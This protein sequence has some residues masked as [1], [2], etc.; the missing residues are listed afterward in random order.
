MAKVAAVAPLD[1]LPGIKAAVTRQTLDGKYPEGWV[2]EQ[3]IAIAEAIEGY[4]LGSAYAEFAEKDKGSIAE[5]KL[6]DLVMLSDDLLKIDPA[7]I[8][9]AK[10]LMTMVGGKIVYQ[11]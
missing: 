10:V 7:A 9:N 2:P 11:K 1:P 8:K 5:G 3:K 4:T 6:A